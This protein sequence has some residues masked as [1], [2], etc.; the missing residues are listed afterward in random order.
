VE[1]WWKVIQHKHFLSDRYTWWTST[2]FG[3][4]FMQKKAQQQMLLGVLVPLIIILAF[5]S[6]SCSN[7]FISFCVFLTFVQ[8]LAHILALCTWLQ[9]PINL[10]NFLLYLLS[11]VIL[12]QYTIVS[13][14]AHR[15]SPHIDLKMSVVWAF[16]NFGGL[17]LAFCL[18]SI[19]AVVPFF[20]TQY[21]FYR[22]LGLVLVLTNLVGYLFSSLYL[23]SLLIFG[24]NGVFRK[25][26]TTQ[27][28]S[29]TSTPSQERNVRNRNYM[30]RHLSSSSF[31]PSNFYSHAATG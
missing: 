4:Y 15:F 27:S 7:L 16:T 31:S 13:G 11:L 25:F 14:V 19:A 8:A 22:K 28:I 21:E 5:A 12:A 24:S 3:N 2:Q 6:Y 17:M 10:L 20:F 26:S 9:W 1:N 29:S 23:P 18:I 30:T